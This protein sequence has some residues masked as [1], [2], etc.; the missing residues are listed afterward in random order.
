MLA[1][2]Y[3]FFRAGFEESVAA[4]RIAPASFNLSEVRSNGGRLGSLEIA[5][6]YVNCGDTNQPRHLDTIP[7]KRH[8]LRTCK[9]LSVGM[10]RS[11]ATTSCNAEKTKKRK[12]AI[13]PHR[14]FVGSIAQVS[15]S[16]A[17]IADIGWRSGRRINDSRP[18]TTCLSN[19][20]RVARPMPLRKRFRL[21]FR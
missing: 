16:S 14:N 7:G 9:R 21:T 10:W 18:N 13:P 1:G 20:T 11:F 8:D 4:R 3:V 17:V 15:N 12:A 6:Q 2:V 19:D 5:S